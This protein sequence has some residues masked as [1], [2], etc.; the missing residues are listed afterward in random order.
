MPRRSTLFT[1]VFAVLPVAAQERPPDSEVPIT[2]RE[3]DVADA[4]SEFQAFQARLRSYQERIGQGRQVAS[5]TSQIL[6]ELRSSASA[7]N[8]FNEG[9]ILAAVAAYVDEVL[10]KQVE[11]VDF[12]ESQ[13][14][15]ISYYANKM[16]S[17]VRPEDLAMLFGTEEQNDLAIGEHVAALDAERTRIAE[18]VDG[19]PE[20]WFDRTTFRPTAAMPPEE[21]RVLDELLIRYQGQRNGL[22]LAKK[23]LELVRAARRQ[24][25]SPL[26]EELEV[27][28][29]LL[30]GQMF[31]A[32]DRVR[33]QMSIDL[34]YLEQLLGGYAR[35]S[36]TQEIL[37]AFQALVELQGDL[38]GPSPE[39]AG[40]L[41]W[42]QDSSTR[43]LSLSAAGLQRPGMLVPRYSDLLRE[44][45]E[46]ARGAE[47]EEV[48]P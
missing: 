31:G 23:R 41:D 34:L 20:N 37:T 48:N 35:S 36:R 30:I 29:D 18:F 24:T 1:L 14:Y 40:V 6:S 25:G 46:G 7:E 16:A 5:E 39:L 11:L 2:I 9:P 10:A 33:L 45:Y 32:L 12:L 8:D 47:A 21:R 27:N 3:L 42:L 13:R 15:R 22:D 44:A 17:S 4:I 19:M 43:R 26:G 28:A 38:E